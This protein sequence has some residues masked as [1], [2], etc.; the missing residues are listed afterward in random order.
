VTVAEVRTR[1]VAGW[2]AEIFA[3]HSPPRRTMPLRKTFAR[4][5]IP[6]RVAGAGISLSMRLLALLLIVVT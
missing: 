5:K 4:K 1:L 2:D 3:G 6:G